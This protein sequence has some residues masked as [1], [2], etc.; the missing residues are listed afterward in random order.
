MDAVLS[1]N[2]GD[3]DDA[4]ETRDAIEEVEILADGQKRIES[5][6]IE[7]RRSSQHRRRES[8]S[9]VTAQKVA[10]PRIIGATDVRHATRFIDELELRVAESDV[11]IRDGIELLA[12]ELGEHS[13]VLVQ[14]RDELRPREANPDVSRNG[15][16]PIG[17][18][19]YS[20]PTVGALD[21][22]EVVAGS[23]RYDDE[24]PIAD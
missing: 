3:E 4:I 6:D 10:I 8:Y 15:D 17:L 16:A 12:Q 5:A 18:T 22:R 11:V 1:Q 9:T 14:Q 21:V 24:F 23:V 7:K 20:Y 19:E 2:F 13:V